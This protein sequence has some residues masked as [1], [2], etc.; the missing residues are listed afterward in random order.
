MAYEDKTF[1]TKRFQAL[2][3]KPVNRHS[4]L[5]DWPEKGLTAYQGTKD[6]KPSIKIENGVVVE[7]D[8]IARADFDM[9]DQFIADYYMRLFQ[10]T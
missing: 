8:G 6:P 9:I 3:A 1:K 7:M 2:A 4:Y 10:N 5:K